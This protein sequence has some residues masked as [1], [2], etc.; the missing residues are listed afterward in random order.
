[1]PNH[2]NFKGE[3]KNY[4]NLKKHQML[5][6]TQR[7]WRVNGLV[8]SVVTEAFRAPADPKNNIRSSVQMSEI[9]ETAKNSEQNPYAPRPLVKD[10]SFK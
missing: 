3:K 5:V 9:L 8:V 7:C 4:K 6:K 2:C 1:M 10:P